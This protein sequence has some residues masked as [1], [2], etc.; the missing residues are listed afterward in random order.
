M[1]APLLLALTAIA[2]NMIVQICA[3][4]V[5]LTVLKHRLERGLIR[6][7]FRHNS[8]VL[9]IVMFVLFGGHLFQIAVWALLF[10]QLDQFSDFAT[11]FYHSTVNFATLGYGDIVMDERWRLLG[12]LQAAGGVL[13]FGLST[14][15][16]FAVMSFL[17]RYH[18]ED[19][20]LES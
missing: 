7:D 1:L 3:V 13:M 18:R 11:A 15:A 10:L 8:T 9:I 17:F 14:G 2:I 5:M 12:A 16:L 19:A 6:P 20:K 4:V